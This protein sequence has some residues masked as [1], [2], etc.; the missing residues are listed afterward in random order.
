MGLGIKLIARRGGFPKIPL[1]KLFSLTA[2]STLINS[3]I[4]PWREGI[5]G[6]AGLQYIQ[7]L[8]KSLKAQVGAVFLTAGDVKFESPTQTIRGDLRV[9]G[10]MVFDPGFVTVT[11]A[12]DYSH[13][14]ETTDWRLK[15]HIG[16][17][18]AIPFFKLSGG[19]NQNSWSGG[20]G[21]RMPGFE[22][23]VGSYGQELGTLMGTEI[24]R[25]FLFT[26][27]FNVPI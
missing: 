2:G 6:D 20:L 10:A 9:G 4:G 23:Y 27:D 11:A 3:M 21:F 19:F 22:F 15:N 8:N 5:G 12:Y 17:E 18:V 16:V 25:R 14:L 13:I 24:T 1:L 7:P 26:M